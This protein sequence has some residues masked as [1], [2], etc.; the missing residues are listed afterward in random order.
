MTQGKRGSPTIW[1]KRE[2]TCR[3]VQREEGSIRE[4]VLFQTQCPSSSSSFLLPCDIMRAIF[5]FF[6]MSLCLGVRFFL[7][8]FFLPCVVV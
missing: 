6:L 7:V 1:E 2:I 3:M 8:F 4:P 5:R